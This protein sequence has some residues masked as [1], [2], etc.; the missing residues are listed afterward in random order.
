MTVTEGFNWGKNDGIGILKIVN[1]PSNYIK[2]P[3]FLDEAFISEILN[4]RSLK[5]III[6]GTGRHFS[7]GADLKMM[8]ELATDKEQ[9]MNRITTGKRLLRLFRMAEIPVIAAVNGACFGAGL[10]IALSCHIIVCSRNALFAFPEINL[11]LF[12]GLEGA[13]RLS[14]RTGEVKALE[15]VLSGNIITAEDAL[16]IGIADYISDEKEAESFVL[17]YL[18]N[19]VKD[20]DPEIIRAVMR[21]LGNACRMNESDALNEETRLFCNLASR[22]PGN[23]DSSEL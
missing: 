4:D 15:I 1:P 9:F 13:A 8:K 7:A 12:P 19:L 14:E 17:N 20:R 22:I 6:A 23:S 11:G 21:S 5:G 16:R 10:E 3:D 2:V 18:N